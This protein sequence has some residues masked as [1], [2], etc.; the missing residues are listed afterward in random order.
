MGIGVTVGTDGD[1]IVDVAVGV[2]GDVAVGVL[3]GVAVG[4]TGDV[5]V[6]VTDDVAVGVLDGVAVGVAVGVTDDVAVGVAGDVAVGVAGVVVGVMANPLLV[7][8]RGTIRTLSS[9]I[10]SPIR[11]HLIVNSNGA[12]EL[13][14]FNVSVITVIVKGSISKGL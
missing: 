6:G 14:S 8:I 5:V 9:T 3:D 1:D 4:V 10:L 11:L 2:A 13:F 12:I 7:G